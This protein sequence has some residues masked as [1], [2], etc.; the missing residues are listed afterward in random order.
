MLRGNGS[1][2]RENDE[3]FDDDS[4]VGNGEEEIDL[5]DTWQDV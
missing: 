4:R 5:R 1:N 2:V 3:H